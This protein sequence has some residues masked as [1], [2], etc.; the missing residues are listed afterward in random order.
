ME[1]S[2]NITRQQQKK[3]VR[4]GIRPLPDD[5]G[6]GFTIEYPHTKYKEQNYSVINDLSID[7]PLFSLER[8]VLTLICKALDHSAIVLRVPL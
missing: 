2:T 3:F 7:H 1:K 5:S 6:Y 8:N 4:I